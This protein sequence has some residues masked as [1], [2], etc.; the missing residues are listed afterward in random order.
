MTNLLERPNY[1]EILS[2]S[3]SEVI[4]YRPE[5]YIWLQM[6]FV[7]HTEVFVLVF[8]F[9]RENLMPRVNNQQTTLKKKNLDCPFSSKNYKIFLHG[10]IYLEL[11]S[12][13][14]L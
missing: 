1:E 4:N 3:L 2:Y 12:S 5:G 13:C 10:D 9:F 14:L 7:S 6:Y 11:N 8:F